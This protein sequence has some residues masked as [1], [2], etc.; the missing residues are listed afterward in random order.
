MALGH[1]PTSRRRAVQ[2]G[3]DGPAPGRALQRGVRAARRGQPRHVLDLW[4]DLPVDEVPIG[5]VTNGVHAATWVSADMSD[6]LSR[7]SPARLGRG[8]RRRWGRL[9]RPR[10]RALAARTRPGRRSGWWP[11]V[12]E[13]TPTHGRWPAGHL[14]V[15]AAGPTTCSTP[16]RSPSASPAASPP[17]SGP[18]C[19]CPGRAPPRL[20]LDATGRC[21]SCSPARPT[22][23]TTPAR[24]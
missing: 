16:A 15:E 24:R 8:R 19:C 23:P 6:L 21:S 3:R 2:H 1:R 14:G 18:T 9:R 10:R 11:F 13:R 17:T 12:R 5:S 22:P 20:L 4:P 7:T